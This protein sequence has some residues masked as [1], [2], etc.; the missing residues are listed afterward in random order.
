MTV[1]SVTS[2]HI[3]IVYHTLQQTFI[4]RKSGM[5][6]YTRLLKKYS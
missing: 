5:A 1:E 4:K 3:A 2:T 6:T